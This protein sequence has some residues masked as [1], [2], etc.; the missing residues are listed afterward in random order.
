LSEAYG[1]GMV[2]AADDQ[3]GVAHLIDAR[4]QNV[5]HRYDLLFRMTSALRDVTRT[6]YAGAERYGDD[7]W[8]IEPIELFVLKAF[9]HLQAYEKGDTREDHLAHAV[10]DLLF[11]LELRGEKP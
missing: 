9:V 8:R 1:P 6:L 7:A 10:C 11:A 3:N 2:V 4:P 5:L